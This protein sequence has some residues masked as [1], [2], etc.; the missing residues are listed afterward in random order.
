[1]EAV[2]EERRKKNLS[3]YFDCMRSK[4]CVRARVCGSVCLLHG[5]R[6]LFLVM[7]SHFAKLAS[8]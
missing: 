8:V 2:E 5:F 4:D 1:M 6:P 3:C 7:G